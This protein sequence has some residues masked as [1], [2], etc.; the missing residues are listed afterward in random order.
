MKRKKN[1]QLKSDR[2]QHH[3]ERESIILHG[4]NNMKSSIPQVRDA[5]PIVPT[6]ADLPPL[7]SPPPPQKQP[8]PPAAEAPPKKKPKQATGGR[9]KPPVLVISDEEDD[10]E[11]DVPIISFIKAK[12]ATKRARQPSTSASEVEKQKKRD[13]KGKGKRKAST[14]PDEDEESDQELDRLGASVRKRRIEARPRASQFLK[15]GRN[16][17]M[18]GDEDSNEH[19]A[20]FIVP[21]D[22]R[23]LGKKDKKKKNKVEVESVSKNGKGKKREVV[24]GKKKEKKKS[25]RRSRSNEELEL[26]ELDLEMSEYEKDVRP[27]VDLKKQRLADLRAAREGTFYLSQ[28][29]CP[30]CNSSNI[31]II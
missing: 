10:D 17:R 13:W 21:D 18:S 12:A 5:I 23:K 9:L 25:K 30:I 3:P 6:L 28:T 27:R 31:L 29:F 20:G 2:A 24:V 11:D 14:S 26:E 7:N 22:D 19:D 16:D 8:P 15:G 1:C 4:N